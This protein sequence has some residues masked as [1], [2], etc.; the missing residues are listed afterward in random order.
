LNPDTTFPLTI[1]RVDERAASDLRKLLDATETVHPRGL[2]RSV[3]AFVAQT[4]L[5]CKEIEEYVAQYGKTF[6][7]GRQPPLAPYCDLDALFDGKR[8]DAAVGGTLV[9]FYGFENLHFYCRHV[10]MMGNPRPIPSTHRGRKRFDEL[11]RVG[12]ATIGPPMTKGGTSGETFALSAIEAPVALDDLTSWLQLCEVVT[13]VITLTYTHSLF[14]TRDAQCEAE[15]AEIL[16]GYKVMAVGDDS[17]CRHCAR[18]D[19]KKYPVGSRPSVPFHLACRC[20]VIE[21]FD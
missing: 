17:T 15:A 18:M 9:G 10:N 3:A 6:A 20:A 2:F 14:A 13:E 21:V 5:L 12:L 4:G 19:G 1:L 16:K 8:I 7:A 11:A